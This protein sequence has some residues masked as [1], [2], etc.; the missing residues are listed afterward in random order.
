MIP[1][2]TLNPWLTRR[3][4]AQTSRKWSRLQA[5]VSEQILCLRRLDCL[6]IQPWCGW[7]TWRRRAAGL[8]LG[9][10]ALRPKVVIAL[11]RHSRVLTNAADL[12]AA[13]ATAGMEA[14]VVN[15]GTMTFAEQARRAGSYGT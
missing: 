4:D 8:E 6:S 7:R 1:A 11:R 13:L 9:A 3:S 5:R 12:A 2:V 14:T 10:P 15:F